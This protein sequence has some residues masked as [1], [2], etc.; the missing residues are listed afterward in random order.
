[1]TTELVGHWPLAGDT[2][3]VSGKDNHGENRNVDLTGQG[4]AGQKNG[5]AV[6]DGRRS[7]I[8]V[9]DSPSLHTGTEDFSIAAHIHTEADI[10]DP[11]GDIVCKFDPE[12]RNGFSLGLKRHSAACTSL[13]NYRNLHFGIDDGRIDEMWA[14][15]G[16]PGE[17]LFVMAL[18]VHEGHLYAG[19]C[20][21]AADGAGHVF[22]YMGIGRWED[23]GSP[24]GANAVMSLA[25]Y[26]GALYAGTGRLKLLGSSLPPS[27]NDNEGGGVFRLEGDRWVSCGK[28]GGER[29]AYA[30]YC[31]DTVHALEVFQ[32]RLYGVGLYTQGLFRYEGGCDWTDCGSHGSRLMT[33]GT[34]RGDL[35]VLENGSGVY[36]FSSGEDWTKWTRMAALPGVTQVYSMAVYEGSMVVG[37]W[38]EARVF[39]WAANGEWIDMGRL[40]EELEVM[41]MAVYNSTLYAGTLPLGQVYRYDGN[42][43]WTCTGQLDTTPDVKFRR[44]WSTAVYDGKLYFGTLPAGRVMSLEAGRSATLDSAL[45][46]GWR[47]LAAVRSAGML[48]VYVDGE[49]VAE[50]AEFAAVDYDL[51]NSQPLRIGCGQHDYFT[52]RIADLQIY[53]GALRA[54]EVRGIAG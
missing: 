28:M 40:G 5:A 51:R 36:R 39:R 50:S 24:D 42:G 47:H 4:P 8:L 7:E 10:D 46:P 16:Q 3:D 15:C 32:G 1:M 12:H 27:S 48:T 49:V 35:H 2:L 6:F 45:A 54:D 33:L 25:P 52:G 18:A 13:S 11:I 30:E 19:T 29:G 44:A 17:G 53:R 41:G 31:H 22:R 9:P 20:E 26:R 43:H 38:P 21:S 34:F 37:T 23:L 14:D